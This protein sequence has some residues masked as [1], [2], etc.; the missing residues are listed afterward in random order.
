VHTTRFWNNLH[1]LCWSLLIKGIFIL[2][3][4]KMHTVMYFC[5]VWNLHSR[6]IVHIYNANMDKTSLKIWKG[7]M[8]QIKDEQTIQWTTDKKDKQRS[9]KHFTK[10]KDRAIQI[11]LKTTGCPVVYTFPALHVAPC[12]VSLVTW[13]MSVLVYITNKQLVYMTFIFQAI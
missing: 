6:L 7:K 11:L 5:F 9:T 8:A 13:L 3:T 12:R 1:R 4:T 2:H 10:T